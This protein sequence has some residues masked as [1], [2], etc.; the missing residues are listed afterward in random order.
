MIKKLSSFLTKNGIVLS[1]LN[2]I[3]TLTL[4]ILSSGSIATGI[5]NVVILLISA[6]IVD[7]GGNANIGDLFSLYF[8]SIS[9]LKAASWALWGVAITTSILY[10]PSSSGF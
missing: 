6:T 1:L 4:A 10:S 9:N 7:L 2:S 8:T 3:S 5:M